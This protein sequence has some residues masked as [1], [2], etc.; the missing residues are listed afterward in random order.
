MVSKLE[1]SGTGP[2]ETPA[3]V[4]L[5]GLAYPL[6]GTSVQVRFALEGGSELH[7]PIKSDALYKFIEEFR[8]LSI[9]KMEKAE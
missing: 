2:F 8:L 6:S 5:L 9:K 1:L 3:I 7:L 4:D